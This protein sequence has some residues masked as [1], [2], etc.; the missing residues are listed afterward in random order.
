MQIWCRCSLA[1]DIVEL[2]SLSC[3]IKALNYIGT[4][5]GRKI[6][7]SSGSRISI[8]VV[9]MYMVVGVGG[10][11]GSVLKLGGSSQWCCTS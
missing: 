11:T 5:T 10:I 9:V 6:N 4:G 8:L 7:N 1:S 3:A 2:S